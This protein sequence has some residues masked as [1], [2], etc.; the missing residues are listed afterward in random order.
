MYDEDELMYGDIV[1]DEEPADPED[2]VVVNLPQK[3]ANQWE[4]DG[5]T[6]SDQ[7]P[8]CPARDDVIIVVLRE[9]LNEYMPDWDQREEEI[10]LEQLEDDDVPY[11]PYP[12]MRLDRVGESH[13]R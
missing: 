7:N 13:L 3:V 11:R 6:L 9:E 12:S 1:H 4:V 2:R 8:A 5:G 10:P